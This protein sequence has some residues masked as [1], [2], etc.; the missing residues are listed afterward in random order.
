VPTLEYLR[1]GGRISRAREISGNA[2]GIRPILTLRDGELGLYR[3]VRGGRRRALYA[4]ERLLTEHA[5]P[6]TPAH[7]GVAHGDDPAGAQSIVKMV[8][9]VRPDASI[10][11][12]CEIG[13][14]VGTHGGPGTLG[15]M[16]LAE[17]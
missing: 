16:V 1:R 7:V 11:R 9:A 14:V 13:A 2:I 8:R 12:V 5:P 15:M 4:F 3:R 6:G 17:P 10:E